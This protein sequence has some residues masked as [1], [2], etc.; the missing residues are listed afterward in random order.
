MALH[1]ELVLNLRK[2][3]PCTQEHAFSVPSQLPLE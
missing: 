3:P 1:H 2:N